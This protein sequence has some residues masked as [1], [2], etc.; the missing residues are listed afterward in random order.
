M[1]C[2]S[3]FCY[4]GTWFSHYQTWVSYAWAYLKIRCSNLHQIQSYQSDE[5]SKESEWDDKND[6]CIGCI[7]CI[8]EQRC[9]GKFLCNV[10]LDTFLRPVLYRLVF[11]F[12]T[13]ILWNLVF[14][15]Y[16]RAYLF[17]IGPKFLELNHD[18]KDFAFTDSAFSS[19]SCAIVTSSDDGQIKIWDSETGKVNNVCKRNT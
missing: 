4:N 12:A 14:D 1:C 18:G 17:I 3:I 11:I 5:G 15:F 8:T 6:R 9:D 10:A 16:I 7:I 19:D 13:F 2:D